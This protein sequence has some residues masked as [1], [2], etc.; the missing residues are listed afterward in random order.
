MHPSLRVKE[1][2]DSYSYAVDWVNAE[3]VARTILAVASYAGLRASEIAGLTWKAYDGKELKVMHSAVRGKIGE[4]KTETSE[5]S[6]PVIR[7]LRLFLD[8]W[9]MR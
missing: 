9:K 3:P 2:Q 6:V 7:Q 5:D 4:T 1:R 8:D